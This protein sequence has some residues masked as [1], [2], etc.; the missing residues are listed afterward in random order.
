MRVR[1]TMPSKEGKRLKEKVLALV[2]KVEEDEWADEW[3]LVGLIDPGSFKL[4]DELLE[5]EVKVGKGSA[6]A[7]IETMSFSVVEGESNIE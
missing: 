4:I 5:K 3:E 7:K 6:P 1:I 2:A